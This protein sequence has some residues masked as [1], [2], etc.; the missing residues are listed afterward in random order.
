MK[1]LFTIGLP[2]RFSSWLGS[3]N[4]LF[5]T[6]VKCQGC[7]LFGNVL[8]G[9]RR[10]GDVHESSAGGNFIPS[11]FAQDQYLILRDPRY[12][13]AYW[14]LHYRGKHLHMVDDIVMY[15]SEPV[16]FMHFSGM[17]DL[18]NYDIE[19]ISQHQN[20]YKMN[21]FPKLRPIFQKYLALLKSENTMHWRHVPYGFTNF[22][23]GSR[24]P[25]AARRVYARMMDPGH[26]HRS[27]ARLF[28]D[29]VAFED[30]RHLQ[31]IG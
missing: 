17:S 4:R 3:D 14:N 28:Q 2:R 10:V 23:D 6:E 20:R 16:V 22:K 25:D 26:S 15:D 12:N 5:R 11:Y 31:N 24:V 19:G 27:D 9:S 21:N 7:C 29:T 30:L 13:I 18:L 8:G 1:R